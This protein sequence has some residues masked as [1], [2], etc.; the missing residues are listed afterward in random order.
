[1]KFSGFFITFLAAFF[2]VRSGAV[3]IE[4]EEKKEILSA[5]SGSSGSSTSTSTSTSRSLRHVDFQQTFS[6]I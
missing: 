6:G 3:T 2:V 1:M 4:D 5:S